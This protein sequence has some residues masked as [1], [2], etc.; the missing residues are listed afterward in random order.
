MRR[1]AVGALVR[2]A[3]VVGLAAAAVRGVPVA[4]AGDEWCDS[5]PIRLVDVDGQ[6][7][8]VAVFYTPGAQLSRLLDAPRL[9]S[10][11]TGTL[12][13][14]STG[15]ERVAGGTKVTLRVTVRSDFGKPFATRLVVSAL[16][17]GNGTRYAAVTGVSD[18]PMIAEFLLPADPATPSATATATPSATATATATATAAPTST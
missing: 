17:Y 3:G 2:T 5:D 11:L 15:T 18:Q 7:L 8:P 1:Q 12:L 16:P 10:L 14:V 6:P 13:R 9:L 4:W